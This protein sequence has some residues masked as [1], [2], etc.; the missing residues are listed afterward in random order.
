MLSEASG[1]RKLS[2]EK[3][4]AGPEKCWTKLYCT[5]WKSAAGGLSQSQWRGGRQGDQGRESKRTQTRTNTHTLYRRQR[6]RE[7]R[8]HAATRAGERDIFDEVF[9]HFDDAERHL[10]LAQAVLVDV[11]HEALEGLSLVH[12]THDQNDEIQEGQQKRE[13]EHA[14]LCEAPV[15]K[16]EANLCGIYADTDTETET[17]T[18]RTQRTQTQK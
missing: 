14:A 7:R 9:N 3:M 10:K 18:Q 5:S 8:E 4:G 13:P 11:F 17:E 1:S 12:G 2:S 15:G 16:H 6:E